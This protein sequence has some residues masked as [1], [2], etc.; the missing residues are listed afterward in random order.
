MTGVLIRRGKHHIKMEIHKGECH[1]IT[2]ADYSA[3]AISKEHQGSTPTT[4]SWDKVRK[5]EHGLADTYFELTSSR[6]VRK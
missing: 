3:V 1:M 4:R 5:G 2:E 6:T